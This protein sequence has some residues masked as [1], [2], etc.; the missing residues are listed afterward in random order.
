MYKGLITEIKDIDEKG[1]V[2][3]AANCLGNTDDQKDISHPGSFQKTLVENFPRIKWLLNHN[4]DFLLGVP[5]EGK[6]V[7]PYLQMRGQLNLKKEIGRDV[8]E[9]YKLYAEHGKTL[10]HSIGVDPVKKE[11]KGDIRHVYEWKLWE[12]STLYGWGANSQTPMLNIKSLNDIPNT[13]DWLELKMRKGNYSDAKFIEIEKHLKILRSLALEPGFTTHD[14]QPNEIN[15]IIK[16]FTNSLRH[17]Q[18][19]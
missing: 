5:L 10:E 17:E 11:Q 6:E 8:Y 9:D 12:Y 3:V 7:N 2:T 14:V 16:S 19:N 1:I 18:R 13:I 4:T 15:N